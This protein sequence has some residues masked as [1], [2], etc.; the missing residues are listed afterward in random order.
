MPLNQATK[1]LIFPRA[2][3]V[4]ALVAKEMRIKNS[5]APISPRNKSTNAL[6]MPSSMLPTKAPVACAY[7]F[8]FC[9]TFA[10]LRPSVGSAPKKPSNPIMLS[11]I[12]LMP[13]ATTAR[14]AG[15][16]NEPKPT[17]NTSILDRIA[18]NA[19]VLPV[20]AIAAST[21]PV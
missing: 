15:V 3:D 10:N 2:A 19:S 12:G 4:A 6:R 8:M 16:N 21:A 17:D 9:S 7:R 14:R 5:C 1:S 20:A 18:S 11:N 13:R